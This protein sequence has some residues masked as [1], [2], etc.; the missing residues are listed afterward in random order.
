MMRSYE[1][2]VGEDGKVRL[3]EPLMALQGRQ[4]AV[5]T[6]LG[7]VKA[8]EARASSDDDT[9]DWRPFVGLLN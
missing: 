5:L 4:R 2:E 7:P 1:A 6:V 3:C 8:E 9:E